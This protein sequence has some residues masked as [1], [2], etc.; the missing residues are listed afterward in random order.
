MK[1]IIVICL[2]IIILSN[3]IWSYMYFN[4]LNVNTDVHLFTLDGSGKQW[5]VVGYKI[6]ISPHKILRGDAKLIFRGDPSEIDN[7]TYYSLQFKERIN[8]KDEVVY[9]TAGSSNNGSVS[10]LSNLNSTGAISSSYSDGE[11]NK[12]KTSFESTTMT[13][14]WNDN[15]GE[16][17]TETIDLEVIDEIKLDDE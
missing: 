10:L 3:G 13:I 16:M 5:D 2:G 1:K 9:T 15:D 4:K 8:N 14:T 11:V 7:S 17:H 6:L 12:D